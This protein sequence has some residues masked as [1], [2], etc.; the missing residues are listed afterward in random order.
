MP[1]H[2]PHVLVVGEALVD[3]VRRAD[4]TTAEHPGGSPANV[5]LTLGRLGRDVRLA[6]HLGRDERGDT[7]RAWLADSGVA[8]TTGSDGAAATSVARAVLDGSG[9]ATYDFAITWDLAPG[10]GATDSTLAVHT[11]SIAAVLEPG[12][13]AV[14]SLVLA[15]REHATITY[16]PNARPSLMGTPETALTRIE[17]LVAAAD[18]VKVSDEDVEWL[19]PGADPVEIA[20][21]WAGAAGTQQGPAIVVVTFGGEGAVAVCAAGEVRVEAPRVDV[22]DTVG[23]GDTF[24]GALVD[25]LWEQDLLGGA[26]RET[27][28]AIDLD[29]LTTVLDRCVAAAAI[30]VSRAGANPPWRAELTN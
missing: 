4:G 10:T 5:A 25:G 29:T 1:S 17:P 26:R 28:R 7:I 2:A 15:A 14:H 21:R 9:A 24:M 19:H 30:T 11:G 3:E 16:D 22:V 27:L 18:V 12:A 23:A 13:T 8:L 6:A 20:R